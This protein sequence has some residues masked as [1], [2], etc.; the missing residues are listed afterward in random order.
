MCGMSWTEAP[1]RVRIDDIVETIVKLPYRS[2]GR[3][4][5]VTG[6]LPFGL[7]EVASPSGGRSVFYR[8]EVRRVIRGYGAQC[9][10]RS[11]KSCI[12]D[13]YAGS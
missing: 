2:I 13:V 10:E 11:R 9:I 8:A 12:D 3:R 6:Y 5:E 4:Y 1:D 7:I